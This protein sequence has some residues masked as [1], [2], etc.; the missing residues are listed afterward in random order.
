MDITKLRTC[1]LKSKADFYY[2]VDWTV[3]KLL[4]DRPA[5]ILKAYYELEKI[6]FNAEIIEK[7]K[8][9]FPHFIEIDKPGILK[10]WNKIVFKKDGEEQTENQLL[11]LDESDLLKKIRGFRASGKKVPLDLLNAYAKVK[12]LKA[13]Y[14]DNSEQSISKQRLQ[15]KNHGR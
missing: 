12:A 4:I 13:T 5:Q 9:K 6:S 11:D 3:E 8:E 10:N 1:T 7:L 2:G 14:I 15:A